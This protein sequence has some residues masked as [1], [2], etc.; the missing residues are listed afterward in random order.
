MNS[1]ACAGGF[2][3]AAGGAVFL[4]VAFAFRA[5]GFFGAFAVLA[6]ALVAGFA[7]VLAVVDL[8]GFACLVA[9]VVAFVDFAAV[10]L[11]VVLAA[12]AGV[13]D[14][15][16]RAIDLLHA[17]KGAR[18]VRRRGRTTNPAFGRPDR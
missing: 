18:I 1:C 13:A 5:G 10:R 15:L 7:A 9:L 16:A 17:P 12:L 11:V 4:A 14:L 8:A 6:G 3:A 2:A